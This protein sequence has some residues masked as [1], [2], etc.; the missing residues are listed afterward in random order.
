[1]LVYSIP[2]TADDYIGPINDP[3]VLPILFRFRG[4]QKGLVKVPYIHQESMALL[5]LRKSCQAV[6]RL[7]GIEQESFQAGRRGQQGDMS[8]DWIQ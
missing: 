2:P 5:M 3:I 7:K 1:V 6:E 4:F 8:R